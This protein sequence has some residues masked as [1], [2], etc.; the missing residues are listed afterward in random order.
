M[1]TEKRSIVNL[2]KL[3]T[4]ARDVDKDA[5]KEVMKELEGSVVSLQAYT[6]DHSEKLFSLTSRS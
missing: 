5:L 6:C 1:V 4:Q 2:R 3:E